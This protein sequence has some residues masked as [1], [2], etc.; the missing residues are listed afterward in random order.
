[1]FGDICRAMSGMIANQQALGLLGDNIANQNTSGY[2]SRNGFFRALSGENGAQFD[3]S[4]NFNSGELVETGNLLNVGVVGNGF[5][6][7]EDPDTGKTY[8]TKDGNFGLGEDGEII[9]STTG[10]RVLSFDESGALVSMDVSNLL[11]LEPE[12]TQNIDF[13]G[14]IQLGDSDVPEVEIEIFNSLGERLEFTVEFSDDST[15]NDRGWIVEVK[16]NDNNVIATSFLQFDDERN[17]TA[18]TGTLD[19]IIPQDSAGNVS[20]DIAVTFNFLPTDDGDGVTTG[21]TERALTADS[22]G[23]PLLGFQEMTFLDDG[24]LEISYDRDITE[25]PFTLTLA[26]FASG[27]MLSHFDG[28]LFTAKDPADMQLGTPDDGL[29]GQIESGRLNGSNVEAVEAIS[30]IILF[31]RAYQANSSVFNTMNELLEET[32]G[33]AR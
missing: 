24:T 31:Q 33:L 3:Q 4:T 13:E 5:F 28:A 16:D 14:I 22:D 25:T 15:N 10:Y 27:N 8:F 1:M 21:T 9:H 18:E 11:T 2:L 23:N 12:Q 26:H 30:Q 32:I 19:I 6:I 17:P 7:L 29:I 20:E